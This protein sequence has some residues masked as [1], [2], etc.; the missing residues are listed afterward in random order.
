MINFLL[1]LTIVV[2]GSAHSEP[3]TVGERGIVSRD[4]VACRALNDVEKIWSRKLHHHPG[5]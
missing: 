4:A 1:F 3:L 2:G 5:P